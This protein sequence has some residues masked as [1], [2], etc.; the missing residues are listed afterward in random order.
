VVFLFVYREYYYYLWYIKQSHTMEKI[1]KLRVWLLSF[2]IAMILSSCARVTD[3]PTGL[4]AKIK[5]SKTL[6]RTRRNLRINYH[7]HQTKIGKF[8]NFNLR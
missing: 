4:N 8:L 5:H 7:Y 2:I 6:K 1:F 3:C